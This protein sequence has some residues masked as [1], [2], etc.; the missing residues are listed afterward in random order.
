MKTIDSSNIDLLISELEKNNEEICCIVKNINIA[1]KS[2]DDTKWNSL[3]KQ[4][5][6]EKLIP[7]ITKIDKDLEE[8]LNTG[9]NILRN[10]SKLYV[11]ADLKNKKLVEEL[12]NYITMNNK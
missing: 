8:Y 5:I 9:T 1:I 11:E 12:E 6:D 2:L 10:T 7:Y 4:K 3:E